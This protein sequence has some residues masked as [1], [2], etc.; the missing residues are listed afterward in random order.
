[1]EIEKNK[2]KLEVLIITEISIDKNLDEDNINKELSNI[3]NFYINDNVSI[4]KVIKDA[5]LFQ[6][7]DID[8]MKSFYY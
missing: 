7:D 2:R 8:N 4:N 3:I 6:W 5:E 1:M